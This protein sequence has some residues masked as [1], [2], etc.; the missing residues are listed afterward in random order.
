M[1]LT[2]SGWARAEDES[3]DC[4]RLLSALAAI[5]SRMVITFCFC[6]ATDRDLP[7][8]ATICSRML[9]TFFPDSGGGEL[10][11][12]DRAARSTLAAICSRMLGIFFVCVCKP[13]AALAADT[14]TS[15][16]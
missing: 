3:G 7:V 8:L 12:A 16:C 1:T 2:F 5:C 9:T 15:N 6:G 13:D 4:D 11:E 14:A 10:E